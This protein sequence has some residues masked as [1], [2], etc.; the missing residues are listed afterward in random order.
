MATTKTSQKDTITFRIPSKKRAELDRLALR[1]TRDRSFLLNEAV[2]AYLETQAW[3]EKHI[4]QG[5]ADAKKGNFASAKEIE[6]V[7]RRN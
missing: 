1:N 6:A 2:D 7:F 5:L 4:E 3:Q